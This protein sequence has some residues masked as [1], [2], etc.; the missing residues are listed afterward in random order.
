MGWLERRV[1]FSG[2]ILFRGGIPPRAE[3]FEALA[4]QGVR[5]TPREATPSTQWL[6]ALEHPQWG[7]AELFCLRG[8]EPPPAATLALDERLTDEERESVGL[9]GSAVALH[10]RGSKEHV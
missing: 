6:L 9:A 3:N 2:S 4:T 8:C 7:S 5:V 10:A 1:D